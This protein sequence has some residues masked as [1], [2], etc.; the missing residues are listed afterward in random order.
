M[1]EVSAIIASFAIGIVFAGITLAVFSTG[2]SYVS[3]EFHPTPVPTASIIIS[4]P[5]DDIDSGVT[6][7]P[8]FA[9]AIIGINNTIIWINQNNT[10]IALRSPYSGYL[11]NNVTIAPDESFSFTF[12]R[13]GIYPIYE[14]NAG[15]FG[16]VLVTTQEL[17]SS[18]L[19]VATSSILQDDS[20]DLEMLAT[21][22]IKAVQKDDNISSIRLNNTQMVA[23]A[24]EEDADIIVP[25]DLCSLCSE[26]NYQPILYRSPLG[27][28]II[29]PSEANMGKMKNFTNAVMQEIGYAMDGTERIDASNYGDRAEITISQKVNGGWILPIPGA[30]FTFLTDWTW[31]ELSRW[32]D[33]KNISNFEFGMGSDKAEQIAVDFMN[34]EVSTNLE[35]AKYG[36]QF[37]TSNDARVTIM[38]DKVMYVVSTGYKTTNPIYSN[39][40]GHCGEPASG[41]FDVLV[42]SATGVPF[43]WQHSMCE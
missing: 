13:T 17:E 5:I 25:R 36:Y 19:A 4:N 11:F 24:T 14:I 41:R 20:R 3:R 22:I 2:G 42:D 39:D 35:L 1:S 23:Y 16:L 10:S 40:M 32:Y 15:K 43:D 9:R 8:P 6:F 26:R 21:T 33:N 18:R 37:G 31:I 38:D 29:Y 12:N 34:N 30:R 27:K 28:P 7:N